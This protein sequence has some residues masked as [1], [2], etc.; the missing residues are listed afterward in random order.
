[1]ELTKDQ[2]LKI[3]KFYH[4]LG[5][6]FRTIEV[7]S[8]DAP[9]TC[10]AKDDEGKEYYMSI[11][12]EEDRSVQEIL[13]TGIVFENVKFYA[14]YA[15][16]TNEMNVFHMHIFKDG[17]GLFFINEVSPEELKVTEDKTY[18]GVASALHIQNDAEIIL[19]SSEEGTYYK[20]A[21]PPTIQLP[22]LQKKYDA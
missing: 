2:D 1:M 10:L 19:P 4:Y 21:T 5:A 16:V 7:A 22:K 12:I 17:Y 9:V 6:R 8:P 14:L 15:M 20:I 18:I 3:S 11:E 13:Q